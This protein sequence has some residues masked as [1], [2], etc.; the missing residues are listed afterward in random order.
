MT[1]MRAD[2]AM[3][4]APKTAARSTPKAQ[5]QKGT[6][7]LEFALVLP[8]FLV[9]LFGMITFSVALYNKT[10]LT[11]ATR[12]GARSGAVYDPDN[13]ETIGTRAYNAAIQVC[14]DHLISF[15][16][17]EPDVVVNVPSGSSVITVTASMNYSGLFI[18]L[19][20]SDFFI[21]ATS[22]MRIESP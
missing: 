19:D 15:A 16:S 2:T 12:E 9:I 18:F 14:E 21:S 8:L 7:L 6:T 11:M 13:E 5:S 1:A 10:V 17:T 3:H 22:S 20:F 4:Q